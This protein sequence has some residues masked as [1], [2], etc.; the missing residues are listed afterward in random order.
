MAW[1]RNLPRTREFFLQVLG[2]L[3]LE[4]YNIV[5][6]GTVQALLPILTGH[7]ESDLH[8]ARKDENGATQVDDFPWIWDRFKE[9][10]YVTAWAEDMAYIGTF[11]MRLKGFLHQPTDHS[12]R[13]Y[14][15]MAEPMYRHFLPWCAGSEVRHMR[16]LNWF[17]ELYHMY[18]NKP[19]FMFGFHSEYSHNSINN[20]KKIDTDLNNLLKYLHSSGY[21]NH[22]ILVLMGDHGSRF[23]NLRA[24]PQGKLEERMPYFAFSFPPSLVKS[25]PK[26]ITNFKINTHRLT[27][28]FDVHKT[29]LDVLNFKNTQD[30]TNK[31]G[32]SLFKEVHRNRSCE[33]ANI[34]R[35]WC[36]C[37]QWT[38]VKNPGLAKVVAEAVMQFLNEKTAKVRNLCAM[39][40]VV[41][42][43]SMSQVSP[44][45]EVLQYKKSLDH[46]G[47]FPDMTDN[48]TLNYN[49]YQIAL[50]T[51]PGSGH[52]EVT[53]KYSTVTKEFFISDTEM[54]RTNRYHNAS[55]C[56]QHKYP[57]LRA[58]CFCV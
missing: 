54:S 39:L 15:L 50:V 31:R 36:A 47:D 49:Y 53:V 24:T 57:H 20:L 52:F 38:K 28:P 7:A 33:D 3:E 9:A 5:G 16:F 21:L 26:A 11:Q 34:E 37:L 29:F 46:H 13:P 1:L 27:T 25:H 23:S 41:K 14:F 56:I 40:T 45:V 2:G 58:Y 19:K 44:N 6:D 30:Y 32:I 17:R 51:E 43:I 10:G 35:H 22:T 18:G 12:M 55:L 8:S 4:G 42:I 48:M